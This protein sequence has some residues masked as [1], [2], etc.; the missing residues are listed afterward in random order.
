MRLL[1]RISPFFVVA[2]ILLPPERFIIVHYAKLQ[3]ARPTGEAIKLHKAKEV[4]RGSLQDYKLLRDS[5]LDSQNNEHD[6]DFENREVVWFLGRLRTRGLMGSPYALC[7]ARN[8]TNSAL[9]QLLVRVDDHWWGSPQAA[10]SAEGTNTYKRTTSPS[11]HQRC[12]SLDIASSSL[13]APYTYPFSFNYHWRISALKCFRKR[14]VIRQL[15]VSR[16]RKRFLSHGL[17]EANP[18]EI[19]M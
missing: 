18:S 13:K 6:S 7:T 9:I 12:S 3:A 19:P 8:K 1:L 17:L 16:H 4:L 14:S 15:K 2:Y 5:D 10:K 11:W